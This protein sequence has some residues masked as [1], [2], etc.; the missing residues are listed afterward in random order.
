MLLDFKCSLLVENWR[1]VDENFK[2]SIPTGGKF[3][4]YFVT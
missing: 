1:Y 3:D 4:N 2:N